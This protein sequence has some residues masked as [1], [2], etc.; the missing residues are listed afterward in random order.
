MNVYCVKIYQY[1]CNRLKNRIHFLLLS[2]EVDIFLV[3]FKSKGFFSIN[4]QIAIT[5]IKM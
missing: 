3:G 4:K 5:S 1:N 2:W